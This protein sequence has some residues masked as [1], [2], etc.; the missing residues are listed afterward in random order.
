MDRSARLAADLK[1]FRGGLQGASGAVQYDLSRADFFSAAAIVVFGLASL[2]ALGFLAAAFYVWFRRG[3]PVTWAVAVGGAFLGGRVFP[4]EL[5]PEPLQLVSNILPVTHIVAG[6]RRALLMG[7][8]IDDLLT[9]IL[10]L[11]AFTVIM[12][13]LSIALFTRSI[14]RALARGDINRY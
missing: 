6:L 1:E 8:G 12:T 10:A 13:P 4:V 2:I 11:L 5:L 9:Q 7:A 14:D 3:E